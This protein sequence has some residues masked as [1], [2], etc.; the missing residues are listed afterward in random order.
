[1]Q[2]IVTFKMSFK[3]TTAI[4][5]LCVSLL[6]SVDATVIKSAGAP[7][8]LFGDHPLLSRVG[9]EPTASTTENLNDAAL[10]IEKAKEAVE[11]DRAVFSQEVGEETALIKTMTKAV[12][13]TWAGVQENISRGIASEIK[14]AIAKKQ[15]YAKHDLSVRIMKII[16]ASSEEKAELKALKAMHEEFLVVAEAKIKGLKEGSKLLDIAEDAQKD[17]FAEFEKSVKA[18]LKIVEKAMNACW[19]KAKD[20]NYALYKAATKAIKAEKKSESK[21]YQEL[22]KTGSKKQL[23]ELEAKF[24]LERTQ[25]REQID[26]LKLSKEANRKAEKADNMTFERLETL[27]QQQ[28]KHI[29]ERVE[30]HWK[31]AKHNHEAKIKLAKK[32]R[33]DAEDLAKAEMKKLKKKY[34]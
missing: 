14:N 26:A 22:K 32:E 27:A 31:M 19:E 7:T 25:R 18:G 24:A 11:A 33:D 17:Q 3:S 4:A 30:N 20:N 16:R 29:E 13:E 9:Y 5:V 1:M 23:A 15:M 21:R 28:L 2:N 10:T 8:T 34:N 12:E 6:A